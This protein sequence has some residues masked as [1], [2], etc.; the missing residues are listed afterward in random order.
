MP[1]AHC[2]RQADSEA[3]HHGD[4]ASPLAQGPLEVDGV[5][6]GF[7]TRSRRDIHKLMAIGVLPGVSI[8]LL[9]RSPS[10]VFQV[11]YSQFTIDRELAEK[12]LVRW[13]SQNRRDLEHLTK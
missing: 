4:G 2:R 1:H 13:K 10:Y 12:V 9:R 5:V 7:Q 11:G 6:A 8:R 3:F